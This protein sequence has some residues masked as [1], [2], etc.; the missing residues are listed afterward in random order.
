MKASLFILHYLAIPTQENPAINARIVAAVRLEVIRSQVKHSGEPKI[1][2]NC[3]L[4]R[5]G[6]AK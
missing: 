6:A 4:V 3:Y 2:I 5:I 1:A